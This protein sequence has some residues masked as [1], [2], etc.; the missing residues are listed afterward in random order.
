MYSGSGPES[1]IETQSIVAQIQKI[2]SQE[3]GLQVL[4]TLHA[5]AQMWLVP[6]GGVDGER[7][8]DY[9]EI[10]G[11]LYFETCELRIL[12]ETL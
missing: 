6:W 3:G 10:V 7:P 11:I 2:Q 12:V 1:E 8:D 5:Y 4:I 9:D